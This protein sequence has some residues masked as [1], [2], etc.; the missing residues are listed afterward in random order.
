MVQQSFWS[1]FHYGSIQIQKIKLKSKGKE[2]SQF[3]YGSIQICSKANKFI[4][5]IEVSIPLWFDS[6]LKK[7]IESVTTD[8]VSI[9]L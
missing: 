9:P 6:N 5:L 7:A 3:H 4:V 1:Q 8:L 2:K